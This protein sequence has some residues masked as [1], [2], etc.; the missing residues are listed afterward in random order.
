MEGA[1][2]MRRNINLRIPCMILIVIFILFIPQLFYWKQNKKIIENIQKVDTDF[3]WTGFHGIQSDMGI[4]EKKEMLQENKDSIVSV[5]LETGNL[6]SLYEARKRSFNEMCKIPMINMDINGP[7]KDEIDLEP[8]LYID[9]ETP[10]QT[11]IVWSGSVLVKDITYSIIL[12]EESGKILD[13][14][15]GELGKD[16]QKLLQEELDEYF[17][18]QLSKEEVI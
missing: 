1:D 9:G 2:S 17:Y 12:E 7:T 4:N 15:A 3:N 6:Y 8:I 18:D 11:M 13:I 16:L 5:S 14:R 10:S